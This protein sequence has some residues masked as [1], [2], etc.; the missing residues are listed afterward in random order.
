[1]LANQP[2]PHHQRSATRPRRAT[3]CTSRRPSAEPILLV[4]VPPVSN[5]QALKR[6]LRWS[7]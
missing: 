1:V 7:A 3:V 6:R 2:N 5:H 4:N